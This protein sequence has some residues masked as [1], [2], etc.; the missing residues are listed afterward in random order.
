M[1]SHAEPEPEQRK[2]A[3]SI[4]TR[5]PRNVQSQTVMCTRSRLEWLHAQRCLSEL[6]PSGD[7]AVAQLNKVDSHALAGTCTVPR[8]DTAM[9]AAPKE[10][11]SQNVIDSIL[12]D[13]REP[14]AEEHV[15]ERSMADCEEVTARISDI[16]GE[17]T[18]SRLLTVS[19]AEQEPTSQEVGV[20][21]AEG[22]I[23]ELEHPA[24]DMDASVHE[25][26]P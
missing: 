24:V 1:F 2:P 3:A 10:E 5:R 23:V 25:H 7:D 19:G 22:H 9:L 12:T 20:K 16:E 4:E 18:E 17:H 13:L 11:A 26:M 15:E 8:D 21:G 14:E 6:D